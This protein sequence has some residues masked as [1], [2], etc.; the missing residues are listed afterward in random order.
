M[1]L[2]VVATKPGGPEVL[3]LV[4]E[5]DR[6]PGPGEALLDVRAA[7]VNPIDFK[8]YRAPG[9]PPGR[10][11]MHLGLE[12]AGVVRE[13]G[14]DAIGPRGPIAVGDE[15]VA[16][17]VGGAYAQRIVAPTSSLVPKP[18]N[19]AWE[20]ASGLMLTG[21]TA[22]HALTAVA[23]G[24]GDTLLFHGGGGGVGVMT[25]QI[26]VDRGARVIATASENNHDFVRSLGAEPV[27]YGDGL[28]DRVKKAAPN[29]VDAAI[30]G[31]GTPEALD[32]SRALVKDVARIAT[33]VGTPA[34]FEAGVKVLGGSPGADPGTEIRN[35]AR[36]E[37]V[38]R[39]AAGT[40]Q[41]YVAHAYALADVAAAH[42]E[43]ADCHTRG[44]IV[45][46][47]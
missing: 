11:P 26:A 1:P 6:K 24:A 22:I 38:D 12:A 27:T 39:A 9:G 30:D 31:V 36:L 16:Y 43:V 29:G 44:K 7:G 19:L 8:F 18:A 33:I 40:L 2:H 23:I 45:L 41:V 21:A 20:P 15:V 25:I 34:A 35:A 10:F 4:E 28:L 32:V 3:E 14:P 37:L 42:R 47:P 46:L 5:P 13:V 17:R